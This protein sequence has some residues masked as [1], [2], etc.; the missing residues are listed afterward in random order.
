[1]R[2]RGLRGKIAGVSR[3]L[4]AFLLCID[5]H[6]KLIDAAK[7]CLRC[8][9]GR[10]E[11]W[12]WWFLEQA[13]HVVRQKSMGE[14]RSA[15]SW[16]A[17]NGGLFLILCLINNDMT[18]VWRISTLNNICAF[19]IRCDAYDSCPCIGVWLS[20]LYVSSLIHAAH[21]AVSSLPPAHFTSHAK[22]SWISQ[23]MNIR[24][25]A[26]R[27]FGCT[28]NFLNYTTWTYI[29]VDIPTCEKQMFRTSCV[30]ELICSLGSRIRYTR[31]KQVCVPL[32]V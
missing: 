27:N 12:R 24:A 25:H 18:Q 31:K 19:S 21:T 17:A 26:Y 29:Y 3:R 22:D 23:R 10:E 30:H 9:D 16:N 2:R 8:D 7:P 5:Q 6:L 11:G 32:H 28:R 4:I 15:R 1:M 14:R 13:I 20:E